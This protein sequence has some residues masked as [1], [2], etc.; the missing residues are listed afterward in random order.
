M[1][2]YQLL[3]LAHVIAFV[4]WL[5]GD[6]GTFYAS[7]FVVNRD[8]S[9]EARSI[10]LKI[11]LGCDQGPKI[12]MPLIFPLGLQMASLSGIA[13]I[14]AWSIV[15]VWILALIWTVTVWVLH[16]SENQDFKAKL[17][18]FDFY[19][20]IAMVLGIVAL[21]FEGLA[22][23]E[24]VQDPWLSYKM[25]IFAALVVCG[26]FIRISL[27]PFVPA[28]VA[29]M[30]KGPDGEINET[31]DRCLGKCRP[32]VYGIWVGLFAN[33]ALGVHLI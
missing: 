30:T 1:T 33:A 11:M 24:W 9:P 17:T 32:Y 26:L 12:S 8:I 23:G 14:P 5:G 7:R 4:Y 27:R 18:Q 13:I 6:M 31:L 2:T 28:F 10:A 21:A 20:R 29:L 16:V 3:E 25:L 19:F 22:I 15:L